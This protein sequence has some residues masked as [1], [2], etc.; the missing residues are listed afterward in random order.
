MKRIEDV[1]AQ[2]SRSATSGPN[3]ILTL[4]AL[5]QSEIGLPGEIVH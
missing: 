3:E 2:Y 5:A 4:T 1:A